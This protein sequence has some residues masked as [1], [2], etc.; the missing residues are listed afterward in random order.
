MKAP[1]TRE[2][3]IE[4]LARPWEDM[5]KTSFGNANHRFTD[6]YNLYSSFILYV[7]YTNSRGSLNAEEASGILQ[8]LMM[9]IGHS[10]K[11]LISGFDRT[12]STRFSTWLFKKAQSRTW[13]YLRSRTE[14]HSKFESLDKSFG[15]SEGT[16]LDLLPNISEEESIAAVNKQELRDEQIALIGQ[17]YQLIMKQENGFTRDKIALFVRYEFAQNESNVLLRKEIVEQIAM[18]LQILPTSVPVRATNFRNLVRQYIAIL[19]QEKS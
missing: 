11:P 14:R 7:I 16:R 6:F 5:G 2:S 8:D 17:A 9:A 12:K 10:K 15:E 3:I 4:V 1:P 18:E 13:D 19:Q